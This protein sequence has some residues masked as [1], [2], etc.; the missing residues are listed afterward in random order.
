[1]YLRHH[2]RQVHAQLED[3]GTRDQGTQTHKNLKL[4]YMH[5]IFSYNPLLGA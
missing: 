5:V 1:M 3:D 2:Q 4:P